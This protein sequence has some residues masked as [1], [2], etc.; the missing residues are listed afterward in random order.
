GSSELQ[1]TYRERG[2]SQAQKFSWDKSACEHVAVYN[3][4]IGRTSRQAGKI[5][6]SAT[7][8][9]KQKPTFCLW[10]NT[11]TELVVAKVFYWIF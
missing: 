9:Q 6:P 7:V 10:I 11:A 3:Q 4:V 5:F 2:L 8:P 1:K